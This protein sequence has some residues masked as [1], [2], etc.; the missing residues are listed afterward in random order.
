MHIYMNYHI[1]KVVFLPLNAS[2]EY[3]KIN[4]VQE[5]RRKRQRNKIKNKKR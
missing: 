3:I 1:S 5:K 4:A 2:F